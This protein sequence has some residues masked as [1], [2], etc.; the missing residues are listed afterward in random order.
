MGMPHARPVSPKEEEIYE[1]SNDEIF[2]FFRI[3]K[4]SK[5]AM[6]IH[7]LIVVTKCGRSL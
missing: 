5:L 4:T 7:F 1:L 6:Y 2:S 3:A